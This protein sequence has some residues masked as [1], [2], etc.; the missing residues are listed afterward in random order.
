MA[1][2]GFSQKICLIAPVRAAFA[3]IELAYVGSRFG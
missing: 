3:V 1:Q 2:Q